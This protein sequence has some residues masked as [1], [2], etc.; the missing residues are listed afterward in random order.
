MKTASRKPLAAIMLLVPM[1]AAMVAATP[2]TAQERVWVA[3]AE[4]AAPR[5]GR[6]DIERFVLRTD[7]RIEAGQELRFR[8]RG[9]P[10]GR[11]VVDIPGV[12]RLQMEE[13]RP[14]VYSA[15][16]TVRRRDN[17]DAF[18]RSVAT[19]QRGNQRVTARVAVRGLERE[20]DERPPQITDIK[21]EQGE[22]V[23]ERNRTH[24]SARYTDDRSGIDP[25]SVRLRLDGRDVTRDARITD[26]EIHYRQDL[27]RG[28]HTAELVVRDREGNTTRRSWNFEV[29]DRD[30]PPVAIVP[31][32]V[33]ELKLFSHVNDQVVG[34]NG[35]FVLQ[36]RAAPG[37]TIRV[38][39]E[40]VTGPVRQQVADMRV[41]ADARGEFTIDVRPAAQ[42]V[43]FATRYEVRLS[44][45]HGNV[46][47]EQRLTLHPRG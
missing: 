26:E 8:L 35:H 14:G 34:V 16:Y 28:R 39:V 2:A 22:R 11:A 43:P 18:E 32:P 45:T 5:Q 7:G 38:N 42:P 19:L 30:G 10:G 37:A 46:V 4:Q 21:P 3:P 13:Q 25:Q 29:F 40:S 12:V 24:I 27:P 20:E 44:A 31:V 33:Q 9:D 41:Q 1:A 47:S 36:G 23:F 17:P 15:T 6:L